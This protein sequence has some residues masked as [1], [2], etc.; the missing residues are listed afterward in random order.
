MTT[1]FRATAESA[2]A[3]PSVTV[4]HVRA[5]RCAQKTRAPHPSQH[6]PCTLALA[7][8][9]RRHTNAVWLSA[10]SFEQQRLCDRRSSSSDDRGHA[11][12]PAPAGD[13]GA[14]TRALDCT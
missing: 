13:R 12:L 5:D 6:V 11:G 9:A 1:Q 4:E 3:R 8:A 2:A 7:R 10:R 14:P